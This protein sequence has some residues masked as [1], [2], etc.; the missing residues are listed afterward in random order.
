MSIRPMGGPMGEPVGKAAPQPDTAAPQPRL[1][2]PEHFHSLAVR[3]L[4]THHGRLWNEN[5]SADHTA[6]QFGLL[7]CL[8]HA[9]DGL[10]QSEISA[11]LAAD[12]ATLTELVRRMAAQGHVAVR[13]DPRDGRRRV[14]TLTDSGRALALE[15]HDPAL[16]VN[17]ELYAPLSRDEAAELTR[18]L[19]K[20]LDHD[21]GPGD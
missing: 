6:V 14:A 10:S 9:P 20:V 11:R 1:R 21:A 7:L 15:L 19:R 2:P 17:D 5:V 8:A 16:Q 3:R 4:L 13:R 18:L 12:K